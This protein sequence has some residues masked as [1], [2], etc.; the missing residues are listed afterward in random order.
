[1]VPSPS[2]TATPKATIPEVKIPAETRLAQAKAAPL[3]LADRQ[4]AMRISLNPNA[5]P[6]PSAKADESPANPLPPTAQTFVP[7]SQ[8]RPRQEALTHKEVETA[9]FAVPGVLE[10]DVT[11][12]PVPGDPRKWQVRAWLTSTQFRSFVSELRKT[13]IGPSPAVTASTP[14]EAAERRK[15]PPSGMRNLYD[16]TQGRQ[17]MQPQARPRVSLVPATQPAGTTSTSARSTENGSAEKLEVTII[18][19]QVDGLL[20]AH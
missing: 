7:P 3:S 10:K 13:G 19:E 6:L 16:I 11:Y 18:I 20:S 1:V 8:A 9:L 12:G 14:E 17:W 4:V 2:P 15:Q 5:V